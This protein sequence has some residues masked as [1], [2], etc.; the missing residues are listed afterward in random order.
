MSAQTRIAIVGYSYRLPSGIRTDKEFWQLLSNRQF[1]REPIVKRFGRGHRPIGPY[2]GPARM[3]SPYEGLIRDKDELLFDRAFFGMS[4]S[5]MLHAI[6]E[7]RMLLNTA[8]ESIER[9]G[10]SLQGLHNSSTGVFIGAQLPA[11][12]NWRPMRGVTIH[13][14]S[15]ISLSMLANRISFHFNLMGPSVTYCTA[16]SAGLSALHA[17]VG[18][19]S[20][21]DCDRALVGAVTYLGSSR[22]SSGFNMM[23]II[24]PD[25]IC[26]SFD[27][28]ANGYLRS[29]GA[30]M[31]A[32]KP[33]EAAERDGDHIEAVIEATA[34]NAA[35]AADGATGLTPGRYISAPTR[36]AQA[37]LLHRA[38][39]KADLTPAAIDYVE[40]HA[41]GTAVG[42]P[43]EGNAIAEALGGVRRDIPL[44]LAS[45]KSNLGHMEAA[46]FTCALTKVVLMMQRRTFAPMSRSF[47]V[48]NPA[49]DFESCPM[50]VQTGCEPFPDH[51]VTVGINSFGFGGANGHCIVREY[52]P[53]RPRTW[54]IPLAPK[55]GYMV[56]LSTRTPA[57]LPERAHRL[58]QFLDRHSP[59]LYSLAGN[60]SRRCT[61]FPARAALVV[62]T[63]DDL[64]EKL[65]ELAR[66]EESFPLVAD[67]G[68]R[69]AMVFSGQG[70][71]WAG[72]GRKLYEAHPVFRRV[73]DTIEDYWLRYSPHSL[74]MACFGAPQSE[75]DETELAQPV[76]FALQCA[77]YELLKTWGVYPDCV[78]AH[79]S[80]EIAAA[81]A[82]GLHSLADATRLVYH[83]ATLQQRIAGSGRMLAISLDSSTVAE[84][85]ASTKTPGHVEIACINSP[86]NTVV[87]APA[88]V[89]KPVMEKLERQGV[90]HTLIAGN[91]AF[92][93]PAMD[94]IREDALE[95]FS[96][97][98]LEAPDPVVPYVSSVTGQ[99]VLRLDSR[100]W[101]SNMREPVRFAAAMQTVVENYN[102]D[103]VLEVAPHSAL[104]PIIAQCVDDRQAPPTIVGSFTRHKDTRT[105]FQEMLAALYQAGLSL[106]F[107]AQYPRPAPI[108]HL[109][110][111]H[112]RSESRLVEPTL[113]DEH[114]QNMSQYAH[115]P[116]VGHRIPCDH[117]LFEARLSSAAFPWMEE[118]RVHHAP[119]MPTAGYIE[120]VFEALEG[121]PLEI[122][123]LELM[124]QVPIADPVR[125]QTA[126]RPLRAFPDTFEITIS[127][128]PYEEA[129]A[130]AGEIHC[131]GRVRRTDTRFPLGVPRHLSEIDASLHTQVAFD[132]DEELYD[133]FS[134]VL[135][136][137]FQYGPNFRNIRNLRRDPVVG[138]L[139][140]ELEMDE[141]LWRGGQSEGFVYNPAL[142][143]GGLQAFLYDLTVGMGGDTFSIPLRV[144]NVVLVRAP[145]SNRMV[146]RVTYPNNKRYEV[147]DN[148]QYSI[149]NGEW[150]S[151]SLSCYD[152]VT[153]DLILN[154]G[155]YISFNSDSKRIAFPN[156]RHFIRWQ[157]KAIT[158][159]H[160]IVSRIPNGDIAPSMLLSLLETSGLHEARVCR[161]AEFAGER[162]P[163]QTV[164][165]CCIDHLVA[166][167]AQSEYWLV[168]SS[169]AGARACYDEFHGH[170]ATLRFISREAQPDH[171]SA[172]QDSL[173][174]RNAA[175]LLIL[176]GDTDFEPADWTFWRRLLISGGLALVV[177]EADAFKQPDAGWTTLRAGSR[178]TLLGAP[179]TTTALTRESRMPVPGP[180]WVI[181]EPS[182][183]A[184]A[185]ASR[186][187]GADVTSIPEAFQPSEFFSAEEQPDAAVVQAIDVFFGNDPQDPTG[188]NALIQFLPIIQSLIYYRAENAECDCRLTV[189]THRAASDVHNPRGAALWGALR[190]MVLEIGPEIR[191][192]LR[193]VD[194]GSED[195]LAVVAHLARHDVRERELVVRD[196]EI[197]V[198]RIHSDRR[199]HHPIATQEDPPYRLFV[200]DVGQ[201]GGLRMKTYDPKP[202]SADAVEVDIDTAALNFRDVMVTLGLLP[203]L[204][205]ERSGVGR[206]I[207]MEASGIV[208]RI[209]SDVDELQV[210]DKVVIVGAGCIANR[211]TA[212]TYQVFP[213]PEG[214][215]M[216][217]AG[218]SLTVLATAYYALV[219]LAQLRHGQ[220]VLIHSAM[221]GVGQAAIALARHVGA[222]IYATAGSD[223]K[224]N[225]LLSMGVAAAFDSHSTSW[226]SE[227][228]QA[229]GD[230][231]DVVLNSLA[232]PH[233]PLCLRALRPGG[234]HCE[235]GK[236]DIYS[237]GQVDLRLLRKNLS[238]AAIDMDRLML[239]DPHLSRQISETCTDLLDRGIVPP[240][241]VTVFPFGAFTKAFRLMASGQHQGKIV[242]KAPASLADRDFHVD[243]R[244][245]FFDPDATYLVTGGLG[246][247]GLRLVPYLV[248]AGAR[249]LTLLDRDPNQRRRAKWLYTRTS[250]P[251]MSTSAEFDFIQ[252]DAS[253][254]ADIQQC[255]A[256]LKKP[257]KGVFHLAG[258]LDDRL[259]VDVTPE[260]VHRIFAPKAC[261]ALYLH[262]ATQG[263]ALDYFVMFSSVAGTFGNVGQTAYGAANAFVD[264]LAAMR[265]RQDLPAL[266]YILAAIGDV[267]MAARNL[268]VLQLARTSGMPP[269]SSSLAAANLDYALRRAPGDHVITALFKRVFW[270]L[271]SSDYLRV[272][273]LIGNQFA[274]DTGSNDQLT[275]DIITT[276]IASKVA[277]LCG[278]DDFNTDEPLSSLGLNS[279]SVAEL[280]AFIRSD[281]N[282]R[283]SALE[284]MTTASCQSLA[285]AIVTGSD[286][287]KESESTAPDTEQVASTSRGR[288][289]RAGR[290]PSVFASDT[291]DHFRS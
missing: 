222:E 175:D 102:P 176:H 53:A 206:E 61:H 152:A 63:M 15:S 247:F 99:E 44:R 197:W 107:A 243:D 256:S 284:L 202:L 181:G 140:F 217:Q 133:Q 239:D 28:E 82:A 59:D 264:A 84:L 257:L 45:V 258:I 166:S 57:A 37:S 188:E 5:E 34:I 290:K 249:H 182:S 172:L 199:L 90:Q 7:V 143:D 78:V 235:I 153:G 162:E 126:L 232:G 214:L 191:L 113:D 179:V 265:R 115:G 114:M 38:L 137:T 26:R 226:Y 101:W 150:V 93:S 13:T 262:R 121:V 11:T 158:D 125:L 151:G 14:V 291:E 195:D 288:V 260:S 8:W 250:L 210:G 3:A 135:G 77:L 33:L 245:P 279:I 212:K 287:A 55:A 62:R 111:G 89:L 220:R 87:C 46:A 92:H 259:L 64:R 286:S 95:A 168:C 261:G 83:R 164:L 223:S 230:G 281:F 17:A 96:F 194:V 277:D 229:T 144:E 228:M 134:A 52:R 124:H 213:V 160:R 266:S 68:P 98:D 190:C 139:L 271:D 201:V 24:S 30:F 32:M 81:Y 285:D 108:T 251:G 216:D 205:F 112:P 171:D 227:L 263:H 149:P 48:P 236:V 40:A 255:V 9:A 22:M 27:A 86:A 94:P 75:L 80:G 189:I 56:P 289:R 50:R 193:L 273:T 225:Q 141:A 145:S 283:A 275:T 208:R 224:R 97:L 19:L 119:I 12:A 169:E 248:A 118:H 241:P 246:G 272:G 174:R 123:R 2:S 131:R 280:A 36:H 274:F 69:V 173:F 221:G 234:W 16:C 71:Q 244:R 147:D 103:I 209:G 128:H 109:L 73:I 35:G 25:G 104:Q 184:E 47:R 254:E 72:C 242:L 42:D 1:I 198:P 203:A 122:E 70:T 20:S 18:A 278:H 54:S 31:Y 51:S 196:G 41:T 268:S 270:E 177:H 88:T 74:R 187:N 66:S 178:S 218:A 132:S 185:W 10:W 65:E 106:D 120:L 200:D 267:G 159:S 60:L 76:V 165:A 252:G 240:L 233:V 238:F 183:L 100:Y 117:L 215:S 49:I 167:E 211:V 136:D 116:L 207:G 148:G 142:L 67:R 138:N 276:R 192:D 105:S 161:I 180:R 85:L 231:V 4:Y 21:S 282:F 155:K 29:E 110:P 253:I 58:R 156:S 23:G 146:C 219:H 163:G 39:D 129:D 154:V 237:D 186:F 127:S 170:R 91:I 204:A 79:S 157:R 43:I 6:P 269:V 130:T